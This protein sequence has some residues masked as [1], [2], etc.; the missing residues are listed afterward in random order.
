MKRLEL[1][2]DPGI[3]DGNFDRIGK[4]SATNRDDL[5]ALVDMIE[6]V[7]WAARYDARPIERKPPAGAPVAGKG[8]GRWLGWLRRRGSS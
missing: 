7:T 6:K 2:L 4:V 5:R 8:G 1:E 3:L